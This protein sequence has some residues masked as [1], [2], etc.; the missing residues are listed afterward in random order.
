[1]TVWNGEERRSG[2]D[3][4]TIE[5]RRMMPYRVHTVVVVDGVTWIDADSIHRRQRIRR[6][7]DRE[8]LANKI[9][10]YIQP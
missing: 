2:R 3:R 1:M 7:K 6:L 5:R 10:H 4:R 8:R 9:F